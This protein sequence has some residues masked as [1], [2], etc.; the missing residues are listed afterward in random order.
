M[1]IPLFLT[2]KEEYKRR[3]IDDEED[4]STDDS[5]E[6]GVNTIDDIES[7]RNEDDSGGDSISNHVYFK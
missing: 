1:V 7:A 6:E 4:L 5:E 3:S 2:I